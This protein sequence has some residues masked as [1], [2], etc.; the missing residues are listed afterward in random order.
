MGPM[1]ATDL[2]RSPTGEDNVLHLKVDIPVTSKPKDLPVVLV[3]F[4]VHALIKR[5]YYEYGNIILEIIEAPT[6]S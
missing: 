4:E 1:E 3:M 2:L 6:S 5:P